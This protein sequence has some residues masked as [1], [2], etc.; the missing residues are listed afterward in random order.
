MAKKE[1]KNDKEKRDIREIAGTTVNDFNEIL[2][3]IR[4]AR[5][6]AFIAVNHELISMYR[7]IGKIRERKSK[8]QCMG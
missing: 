3:I 1:T 5:E 2:E 7:D 6:R 4:K 8:I